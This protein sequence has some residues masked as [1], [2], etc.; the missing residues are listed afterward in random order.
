VYS[1]WFTIEVQTIELVENRV[2]FT[3]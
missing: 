1:Q 3:L 2:Y